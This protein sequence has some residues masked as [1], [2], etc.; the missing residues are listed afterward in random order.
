MATD[1]IFKQLLQVIQNKRRINKGI[2]RRPLENTDGFVSNLYNY[3][4]DDGVAKVRLGTRVMNAETDDLWYTLDSFRI[5]DMDIL[6]G[7]NYKREV[8]AWLDKWPETNF[9]VCNSSPFVRY[10]KKSSGG[11]FS[12]TRQLIFQQGNRFWLEEDNLGIIIINDYGEAYRI[13]KKGSVRIEEDGTEFVTSRTSNVYK[14]GSVLR[15]Y[16]DIKN[17]TNK[18]FDRE[19]YL[20]DDKKKAGW[21]IAGDVRMA[22]VNEMDIV[23]ELSE[24]INLNEYQH[25]MASLFPIFD[26]DPNEFAINVKR[27][28]KDGAIADNGS[29]IYEGQYNSGSGG[30]QLAA[31]SGNTWNLSIPGTEEEADALMIA[32]YGDSGFA[33]KGSGYASPTKVDIPEGL[34]L[35]VNMPFHPFCRLN[36]TN[37]DAGQY[38]RFTMEAETGQLRYSVVKQVKS[39]I[40]SFPRI[41]RSSSNYV[42]PEDEKGNVLPYDLTLTTVTGTEWL[43][44]SDTPPEQW[45]RKARQIKITDSAPFNDMFLK[46]NG[47]L[48]QTSEPIKIKRVGNTYLF[49]ESVIR[50][51]EFPVYDGQ[52]TLLSKGYFDTWTVAGE[53]VI[54]IKEDFN[55]DKMSSAPATSAVSE[56]DVAI[57]GTKIDYFTEVAK[58]FRIALWNNDS[59]LAKSQRFFYDN[60]TREIV[61]E[62]YGEIDTSYFNWGLKTQNMRTGASPVVAM[63]NTGIRKISMPLP[64]VRRA[65]RNPQHVSVSGGKLYVVEDNKLWFGSSAELM[66]TN[67]VELQ[68]GVYGIAEFDSGV[69]VTTKSG[70]FY[71]AEGQYQKVYNSDGVV[72][73]FIA[74][75]SGGCIAVEDKDVYLVTKHVTDS[76][77]WYPALQEIGTP[78]SE[79]NFVGS[80]KSTSIGY[81]IYLADDWNVWVFN[82]KTKAWSGVFNY[83]SKIQK[84]FR[85]NNKLGVSFCSDI[86]KRNSFDT[87]VDGAGA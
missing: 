56:F 19:F 64:L 51:F 44:L 38:T 76:G 7:I 45:K 28:V 63:D 13:I 52:A 61:Y 72:A 3:E 34:Y 33:D 60:S 69:V 77:S 55:E 39:V 42:Y 11:D 31:T 1:N 73:S 10:Q 53:S 25:V 14:S 17:A 54:L 36:T 5:G 71:V 24:P 27:L 66:L 6:I 84:V 49:P 78:I 74:P 26:V 15:L 21:R 20:M 87:P 48:L 29:R 62:S 79:V 40:T 47:L 22:Y 58:N 67:E 43:K 68:S 4:L 23:S 65:M 18:V 41:K 12:E 37:P 59:I 81:K 8:W 57:R 80:L 70:M 75:C 2:V 50:G 82:L 9:K 32:V 30:I 85:F 16:L 86:D 35:C 83:G 46:F